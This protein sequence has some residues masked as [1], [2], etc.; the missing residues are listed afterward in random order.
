MSRTNKTKNR[1]RQQ[2]GF[3]LLET[4]VAMVVM[5]IGGSG[6]FEP[7]ETPGRFVYSPGPTLDSL[8]A[9]PV[10]DALASVVRAVLADRAQPA[11]SLQSKYR[12]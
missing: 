10:I 5:M 2:A 12:S 4:A 9:R 11:G 7:Y 3:S 6:I 8:E 1:A